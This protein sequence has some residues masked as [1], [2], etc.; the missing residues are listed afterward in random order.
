MQLKTMII[1][2]VGAGLFGA[3]IASAIPSSKKA[4]ASFGTFGR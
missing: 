3:V 2:F 1:A 4:V